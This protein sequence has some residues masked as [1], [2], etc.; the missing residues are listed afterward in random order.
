MELSF[1]VNKIKANM[2]VDRLTRKLAND[3]LIN[4]SKDFPEIT[5]EDV[6][7]EYVKLGGLLVSSD[8]VADLEERGKHNDFVKKSGA[9][10]KMKEIVARV[11]KTTKKAKDGE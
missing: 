7:K 8:V 6:K 10:E 9:A 2:A 5:E 3:R 11:P 1:A 4:P